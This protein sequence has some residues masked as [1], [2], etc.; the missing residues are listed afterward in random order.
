MFLVIAGHLNID[1]I[2]YW[3]CLFRNVLLN[4]HWLSWWRISLNDYRFFFFIF[5]HSC[6][7]GRAG[8]MHHSTESSIVVYYWYIPYHW[9]M[10]GSYKILIEAV[11][12]NWVFAHLY[13]FAWLMFFPLVFFPSITFSCEI[14]T[15]LFSLNGNFLTASK[16]SIYLSA[17]I[18]GSLKV[19]IRLIWEFL[20][21][22]YYTSF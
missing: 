17:M 4:C 1:V 10:T 20:K 8:Y 19:N 21:M 12:R 7:Q 13:S 14:W 2:L 15:S 3:S 6:V 9:L 5:C 22:R 16:A 18:W 11:A